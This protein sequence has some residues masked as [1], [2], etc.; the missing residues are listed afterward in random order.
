MLLFIVIKA[1]V[2][3]QDLVEHTD[4]WCLPPSFSQWR[5]TLALCSALAPCLQP[6]WIGSKRAEPALQLYS[7][8]LSASVRPRVR[9]ILQSFSITCA[10]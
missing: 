5:S 4:G 6:S 3:K 10:N 7:L 9:P 1:M 8:C 2:K